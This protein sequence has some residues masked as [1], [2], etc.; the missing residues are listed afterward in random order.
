MHR[1]YLVFSTLNAC[2]GAAWLSFSL[3]V[4][5]QQDDG[6]V[7]STNSDDGHYQLSYRSNLIPIE[8][9]QIHSWVIRIESH[10]GQPI[11]GANVTVEGG[12]PAHNHGLPTRPQV[13]PGG[14]PGD[15]LIEGLRFH[16]AGQWLVKVAISAAGVTDSV[17]IELLL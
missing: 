10:D 5:A 8:I 16:M 6:F 17:T 4:L 12:M 14:Q 2:V 15:Y 9:N 7:Q 1:R 11:S 3:P 13:T